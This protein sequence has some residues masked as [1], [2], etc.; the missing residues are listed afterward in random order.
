MFKTPASPPYVDIIDIARHA[1]M[2]PW[3]VPKSSIE[4]PQQPMIDAAA[5]TD[6][7][8]SVASTVLHGVFQLVPNRTT[9]SPPVYRCLS[10]VSEYLIPECLTSTPVSS[11]PSPSPQASS[12]C[13]LNKNDSNFCSTHSSR[14]PSTFRRSASANALAHLLTPFAWRQL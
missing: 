13:T 11:A 14:A 8:H 6:T 4:S 3:K 2:T 7:A 10:R 5:T 9:P 1:P 12:A